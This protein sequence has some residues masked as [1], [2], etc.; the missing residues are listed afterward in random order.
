MAV[1]GSEVSLLRGLHPVASG[2]LALSVRADDDLRAGDRARPILLLRGCVVVA[3]RQITRVR[4]EVSR[5]RHE[6]AGVRDHVML[7]GGVQT[8][9][10]TAPALA[11]RAL[12]H[13]T[14]ELVR[15]RIDAQREI[16]IAG[17]LVTVGSRLVAVSERLLIDART[18]RDALL[19]RFLDRSIR[20]I[21][22]MIA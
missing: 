16:A 19:Q 3:H 15:T 5:Q 17:S 8:R 13:L 20:H 22:G 4:G 7:T 1:F 11:R 14:T 6:I 10:G 12:A 2:T 18:D 9:L 21:D